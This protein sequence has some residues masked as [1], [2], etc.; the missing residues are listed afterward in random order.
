MKE[1][2]SSAVARKWVYGEC[3]RGLLTRKQILGGHILTLL[4]PNP[5]EVEL[6]MAQGFEQTRIH[7]AEREMKTYQQQSGWP[8]RL[9]LYYGEME[10]YLQFCLLHNQR[11]QFLNLDVEGAYL[12]QLH[13][14]MTEVM[15][16]CWRN[17]S[18]VLGTYWSVG[19]QDFTAI[20]EGIK[21]FALFYWLT[22]DLTEE[23]LAS[24]FRRYNEA[25]YGTTVALNLSM[26][27][28]SWMRS[29][30]EHT[31][32]AS[33]MVGDA[34]RGDVAKMLDQFDVLWARVSQLPQVPLR[35][36]HL[37]DEVANARRE[38][39]LRW[40]DKRAGLPRA[41]LRVGELRKLIYRSQGPWSQ[42]G[43]F[44]RCDLGESLDAI[45]WLEQLFVA[46]MA[47]PLYY[48]SGEEVCATVADGGPLPGRTPFVTARNTDMKIS[49]LKPWRLIIPREAHW[50]AGVRA[51]IEAI[52][53][54][55]PATQIRRSEAK[56]AKVATEKEEPMASGL[57]NNKGGLTDAGK[58]VVQR[59]GRGGQPFSADEIK[60]L[61]HG[62]GLKGADIEALTRLAEYEMFP[63]L[64]GAVLGEQL[65][66]DQVQALFPGIPRGSLTAHIAIGRREE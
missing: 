23:L 56:T 54:Q 9:N 26:R 27:D 40:P 36:S 35:L 65:D 45:E 60:K 46:V 53:S 52:R 64:V 32:V 63:A 19:R 57:T 25:G 50:S 6:L 4:G 14:A 20:K 58:A 34:K 41:S 3:L 24:C 7:S 17:P 55:Q 48:V 18:V 5:H 1:S 47:T 2:A 8:W 49:R 31:F 12:A 66:T 15:L 29:I 43:C 59:L 44:L 62:Y 30:F 13:A 33:A 28:F 37:K 11:W 21:S 39:R 16:L 42:S 22:P 38:L 61:V 51:T 10:D